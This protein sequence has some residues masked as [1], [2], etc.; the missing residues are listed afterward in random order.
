MLIENALARPFSRWDVALAEGEPAYGYFARL[1]ANEG[2]SSMRVYANEIGLNGRN[3]VPQEF[4]A[5]IRRLPLSAET[6]QAMD[7]WTPI[8]DGNLYRLGAETARLK[9][10]SMSK[11]RWCRSCVREARYHRVWWDFVSYRT[12]PTHGEELV[13]RTVR[14]EVVRWHWPHFDVGPDGMDLADGAAPG[15]SSASTYLESFIEGRLLGLKGL[16]MSGVAMHHV[17]DACE[18][19]GTFLAEDGYAALTMPEADL[20][21]RLAERIRDTVPEETRRRGVHGSLGRL[22]DG[23]EEPGSL[24]PW[25]ERQFIEAFALVGRI[26][27]KRFSRMEIEKRDFT[28]AEAATELGVN[29]KGLSRFAKHFGIGHTPWKDVHSFSKDDVETLRHKLADL[30]TLPE[31][32]PIT[33]VPGHEFRFLE[34]AGFIVSHPNLFTASPAVR[35]LRDD[36]VNLVDQA[37]ARA[38]ME[39]SAAASV[40]SY[41]RRTNQALGSVLVQVLKGK[42]ALVGL[43]PDGTGLRRLRLAL[44]KS[45]TV[46]AGMTLGEAAALT[47]LQPAS[48]SELVSL[49]VIQRIEGS[50]RLSE[51]SV[52]EFHATYVNAALLAADLGCAASW[53]K[54]RL[55]AVGAEL[56]FQLRTNTV[57][58]REE[59][60]RL[61]DALR[62]RRPRE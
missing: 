13:D 55:Q 30:I 60:W 7:R 58:T 22:V 51:A 48:I 23:D 40:S 8:R 27:R 62:P 9:Q 21:D 41:A 6:F 36:V 10:M 39:T 57:L 59:A 26:G 45:V 46:K 49:G 47:K 52:L 32:I 18:T 2:H 31:T 11:R 28:L 15:T 37:V 5:A 34:R 61:R 12:C 3:L 17:I 44:P 38:G 14:E 35:Y 56:A 24:R 1:V 33:G 29:P 42:L 19:L 25:L 53:A 50:P 43:S 4:L 20:R 54:A 16:P